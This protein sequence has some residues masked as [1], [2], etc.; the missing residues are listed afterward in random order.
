[1]ESNEKLT[2]GDVE[3]KS[4][5]VVGWRNADDVAASVWSSIQSELAD[6]T[7]VFA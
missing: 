6:G 5:L 4:Q 1:M 7:L 3:R 2:M